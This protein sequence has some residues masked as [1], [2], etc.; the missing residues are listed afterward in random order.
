MTPSPA[1][2]DVAAMCAAAGDA[3]REQQALLIRAVWL[4][5]I[6]PEMHENTL[7]ADC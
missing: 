4:T 7:R 2:S 6:D 3:I 1:P 5:T